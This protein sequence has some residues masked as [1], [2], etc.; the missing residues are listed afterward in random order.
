LIAQAKASI[1]AA[2]ALASTAEVNVDRSR[3]IPSRSRH[4]RRPTLRSAPRPLRRT[5]ASPAG[6]PPLPSP[7]TGFPQA[8]PAAPSST[9]AERPSPCKTQASLSLSL[10]L[11]ERA[12]SSI[13][14]KA[15]S[16]SLQAVTQS[17]DTHPMDT[18]EVYAVLDQ[19]KSA[20]KPSPL[21]LRVIMG[22][23]RD[24]PVGERTA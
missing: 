24:N 5:Q 8:R 21:R 7:R 20:R 10:S 9:A 12:P 3:S 2:N 11:P 1:D 4:A 22:Q 15:L 16:G 6:K 13:S 17:K 19:F 18:N 14:A 23:L